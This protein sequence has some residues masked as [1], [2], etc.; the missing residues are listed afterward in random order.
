MRFAEITRVLLVDP[1]VPMLKHPEAA[2]SDPVAF[3]IIKR[4]RGW[5]V[6]QSGFTQ[7]VVGIHTIY[8]VGPLR[9]E[10]IEPDRING[11]AVERHEDAVRPGIVER[12]HLPFELWWTICV[13]AS[14]EPIDDKENGFLAKILR[15]QSNLPNRRCCDGIHRARSCASR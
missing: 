14:I 11:H 13:V 1:I 10:E 15:T 3:R 2:A 6:R 9:S 12:G 4:L 7:I 8:E 5:V